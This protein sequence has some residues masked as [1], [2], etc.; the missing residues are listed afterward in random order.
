MDF[1]L[2]DDLVKNSNTGGCLVNDYK[3]DGFIKNPYMILN[4]IRIVVE[5]VIINIKFDYYLA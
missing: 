4:N 3:K 5:D 2:D 1:T